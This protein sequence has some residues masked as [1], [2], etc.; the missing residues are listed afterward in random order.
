[1]CTCHR[2][3]NGII[4]IGRPFACIFV[5]V[6]ISISATTNMYIHIHTYRHCPIG[7]TDFLLHFITFSL[8][9]HHRFFHFYCFHIKP[10]HYYYFGLL[11]LI[12]HFHTQILHQNQ[13]YI[14]KFVSGFQFILVF[15]FAAC[16]VERFYFLSVTFIISLY[17]IFFSC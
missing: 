5:C 9:R 15:Y 2:S 6:L 17:R 3:L 11:T 8:S 7:R 14:N 4:I 13:S 10:I 1:M 16:F 12:Y